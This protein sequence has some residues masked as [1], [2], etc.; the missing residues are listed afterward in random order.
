MRSRLD[1]CSNVFVL[2]VYNE[3]TEKLQT[4]RNHFPRS[5]RTKTSQR[6]VSIINENFCSIARKNRFNDHQS[7]ERRSSSVFQSI[8]NRWFC[9]CR[10]SY[11]TNHSDRW[12]TFRWILTYIGTSSQIFRSFRRH[13]KKKLFIFLHHLPFVP[14]TNFN[15]WTSEIISISIG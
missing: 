6:I 7:I 4:I 13:L 5:D 12:R 15:T 14:R 8:R 9:S 10:I 11:S 2:R 1:Q 3:R